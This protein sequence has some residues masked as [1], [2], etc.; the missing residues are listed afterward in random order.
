MS[1]APAT[2]KKRGKVEPRVA[3]KYVA[4]EKMFPTTA[5]DLRSRRWVEVNL[6]T[7]TWGE[8]AR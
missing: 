6:N 5:Q 2:P 3:G 8:S 7:T 4:G 1:G